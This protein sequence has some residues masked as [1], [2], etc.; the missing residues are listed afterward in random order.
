[1]NRGAGPGDYICHELGEYYLERERFQIDL[2][3]FDA[4]VAEA[5]ASVGQAAICAYQMAVELYHTPYFTSLYYDW[6]EMERRHL[7]ATYLTALRILTAHYAAINDYHRAIL[8]CERMLEADPL[9]EQVHC[10]LMRFWHRLGNRA[11]VVKQYRALGR[12]L[13]D[14]LGTDPMPETQSLYVELTGHD[15]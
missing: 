9:L 14:E 8:A 10:D 1:M 5:Q 7:T 2:D 13:A 6:S 12:L 4:Y 3:L 15:L 11:A